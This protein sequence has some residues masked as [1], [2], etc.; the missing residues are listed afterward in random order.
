MKLLLAIGRAVLIGINLLLINFQ[1]ST[2]LE[3][4]IFFATR[5]VFF[6]MLF[7]DYVHVAY[8][9]KKLERIIGCIGVGI[10]L[11][12]ALIDAAGFF[13][14]I[15]LSKT[16]AGYVIMGNQKNFISMMLN[17]FNAQVYIFTSWLTIMVLLGFEILNQGVRHAPSI[18]EDYKEKTA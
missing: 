18:A 11:I 17:E 8:Y 6:L 12:F 1:P 5:L 9:N 15:T 13:E 7:I 4:K 16:E 3:I 2:E 14:F 10:A